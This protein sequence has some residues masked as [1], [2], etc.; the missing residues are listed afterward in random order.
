MLTRTQIAEPT[1]PLLGAL[2][3]LRAGD[4]AVRF[5]MLRGWLCN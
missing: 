5:S 2:R 4:F 3:A 1:R